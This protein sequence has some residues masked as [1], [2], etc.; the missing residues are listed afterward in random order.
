M[1]TFT[2]SRG[3]P[4]TRLVTYFYFITAPFTLVW[5]LDP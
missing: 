1:I 3:E 2:H 5:Q 4:I